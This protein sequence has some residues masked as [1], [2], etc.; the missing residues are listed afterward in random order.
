MQFG[1]Q[2]NRVPSR[3][4]A[5]PACPAAPPT[6]ATWA[7]FRRVGAAE[8]PESRRS[9]IPRPPAEHLGL[10]RRVRD[11]KP[12]RVAHA[13]PAPRPEHLLAQNGKPS[14]HQYGVSGLLQIQ[15]PGPT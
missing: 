8:T 11:R 9:P 7:G 13:R 6:S 4:S 15:S 10:L 3:L 14:V 12:L 1:T 2:S 5:V